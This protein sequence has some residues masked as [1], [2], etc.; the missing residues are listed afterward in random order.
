[1][2]NAEKIRLLLL[3]NIGWFMWEWNDRGPGADK[4]DLLRKFAKAIAS[5]IN[6]DEGEVRDRIK[7]E[8]LPIQI[9]I[10]ELST[11]IGKP[12]YK[13]RYEDSRKLNLAY[14]QLVNATENIAKA[15]KKANPI[16]VEIK[17]A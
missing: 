11:R 15:L 4:S 14:K 5:K 2:K 13:P 1:M 17:D 9:V 7:L 6:I 8:I 16:K 12:N 10:N 3:K